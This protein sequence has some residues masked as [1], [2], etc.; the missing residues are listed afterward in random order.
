MDLSSETLMLLPPK[1][2]T[3]TPL[4]ARTLCMCSSVTLSHISPHKPRLMPKPVSSISTTFLYFFVTPDFRFLFSQG[5]TSA[6]TPIMSIERQAGISSTVFISVNSK[7]SVT[8]DILSFV[9]VI[10]DHFWNMMQKSFFTCE[11]F[12]FAILTLPSEKR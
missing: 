12:L 10:F 1:S 9:S 6:T 2:E 8:I 4:T 5:P 7:D 3:V 11:N